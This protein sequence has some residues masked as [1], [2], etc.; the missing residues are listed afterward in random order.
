MSFSIFISVAE[1]DEQKY[2]R[3]VSADVAFTVVLDK[4]IDEVEEFEPHRGQRENAE[5]SKRA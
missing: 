3:D 4:P 5:R 2:K 1:R